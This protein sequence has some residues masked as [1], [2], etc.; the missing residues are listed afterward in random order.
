MSRFTPETIE[1][2]REAANIVEIVSEHTDLRQAGRAVRRPL[3]LP[4]RAHP[5][6][7]GQAR[8]GF[9]YCFGCEAGGDTI[10]FVQEKEGLT[11]PDAVE[12][13]AERYGVEIEVEQEDPKAEEARRRRGRLSEALQRASAFYESFLWESDEGGEREDLPDRGARARRGGP[14]VVR[15]RVRAE[16]LGLDPDPRA[17]RR[18][19]G[20]GA[21]RRGPDPALAEP[22]RQ[23]LRPLPRPDHVPGEGPPRSR[24]RLRRPRDGRRREAEV[25]ELARERAVPQEPHA[26]RHRPGARADRARRPRGRG[27]GLH[28]RARPA[29]GG[30]RGGRGGD[31]H[32][33]HARSA[34]APR[35]ATRRRSCSPSTPTARGGRRCCAR[36][37]STAAR[38]C[39]C[40][41][42]RC[43]PGEDPADMMLTEEGGARLRKALAE[44]V[45]LAVFHVRSILGDA[46]LATPDRPRPCAR[47]GRAGARRDGGDD[48]PPGDGP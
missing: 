33:D 16:R 6:V 13:L 39:G 28:G 18:V 10:G 9:Y 35:R 1:R 25:P 3:P 27:R 45:D 24:G 22:P 23:P 47:R 29:S 7:L 19:L 5:V 38:S 40:W 20:A 37:A 12:S 44:A 14:A 8:E 34:R 42:R 48:H 43:P 4:R 15:G 41:S 46:D 26:L 31:G 30:D 36:S 32:G 2:V 17:A 21:A 11:F